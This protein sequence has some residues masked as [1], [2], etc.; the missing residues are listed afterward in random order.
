MRGA[1]A[2]RQ[3][4]P[5]RTVAVAGGVEPSSLHSWIPAGK[6]PATTRHRTL[7]EDRS[8]RTGRRR[9][10]R[11]PARVPE[12]RAGPGAARDGRPGAIHV[13][14]LLELPSGRPAAERDRQGRVG[15][16]EGRSSRLPR[17]LLEPHRLARSVLVA[18]LVG[19]AAGVRALDPRLAGL[20]ASARRGRLRADRRLVGASRARG[21]RAE[22]RQRRSRRGDDRRTGARGRRA[23]RLGPGATRSRDEAA[24]PPRGRALRERRH[25]GSDSRREREPDAR[26]RLHRALDDRHGR[27]QQRGRGLRDGRDSAGDR[28][29]PGSPR[30]RR[31]RAGRSDAGDLRRGGTLRPPL[32]VYSI[33]HALARAE[34]R[35]R[36]GAVGPR[37]R[38]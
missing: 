36:I 25:D 26:E 21:D 27:P 12:A 19:A 11:R 35:W 34:P 22:A 16:R 6:P 13:T 32:G 10:G 20:H 24:D 28:M 4:A 8:R 37:I 23:P 2:G 3:P 5:G 30:R 38:T 9:T 14:G 31:V 18:A 33:A 15:R 7:H 1:A 29:G 17:R